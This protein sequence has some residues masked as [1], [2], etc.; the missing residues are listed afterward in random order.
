MA[1]LQSE[2]ENEM[3]TI[4]EMTLSAWLKKQYA[5]KLL[6]FEDWVNRSDGRRFCEIAFLLGGG[7][8]ENLTIS[9]LYELSEAIAAK[10][11]GQVYGSVNIDYS[12][13]NPSAE[14]LVGFGDE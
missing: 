9:K 6:E 12:G 7:I 8:A 13:T 3:R 1:L 5:V 10:L 14:I 2:L 11:G 4:S